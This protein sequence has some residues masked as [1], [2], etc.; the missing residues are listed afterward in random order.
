MEF[1]IG[2]EIFT[3]ILMMN[4]IFKVKI[5]DIYTFKEVSKKPKKNVFFEKTIQQY[6]LEHWNKNLT[7]LF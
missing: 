6:A 4:T 3:W 1:Y 7:A 5:I 2:F